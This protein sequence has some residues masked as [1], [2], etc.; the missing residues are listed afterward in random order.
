[1]SASAEKVDF[2][3]DDNEIPG[4]RFCLLSFLSP[5]NVLERK[6]LFFFTKFMENYEI[7]WKTVNFEKY[8]AETIQ[9][10]NTKLNAEADRLASADCSAASEICRQ[11]RLNV[12][13]YIENFQAYQQK[14]KKELTTTSIKEKYDDFMYVHGKKVEDEFFAKNGFQTTVRGLK[15][16]GSYSNDVEAKA[17]A[18]KLQKADPLHNIYVAEVGK[19]LAWD[20]KPHEVPNQEYANEQL[21]SLMKAYNENESAK[22]E[23]FKQHV[24]LK[25]AVE[26]SRKKITNMFEGESSVGGDMFSTVGDLALQRKMENASKGGA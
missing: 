3:D 11:A 23:A 8:L 24:P 9:S 15:V 10:I 6:D 26:G 19:W 22:S 2:L 25:D 13:E 12:G 5:E 20:P 16:R 14:N 17:R 4:Q 18:Q 1:M 7:Q 21:N